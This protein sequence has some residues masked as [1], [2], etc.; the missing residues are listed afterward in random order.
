M[1]SFFKRASVLLLAAFVFGASAG[2]FTACDSNKDDDASIY[3]TWVSSYGEE[4]IITAAAFTSTG[5]YAG[6]I[7]NIRGDGKGAGY[8][9]IKYTGNT[10]YGAPAVG[11]YYVIHY[12]DL[13]SSTVF[14]SGAYSAADTDNGGGSGKA[15]KELAESTYTTANGYFG[16]YSACQ[17]Q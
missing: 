5:A 15:T 9:T 14:L 13:N 17:K 11:K 8:I 10:F 6:T 7:E 3:A 1:F 4:Y 16:F 2:L 12:K